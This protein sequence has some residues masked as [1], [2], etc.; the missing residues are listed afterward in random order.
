MDC[1][2]GGANG[3]CGLGRAGK[4]TA[5]FNRPTATVNSWKFR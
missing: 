1:G 3:D 4:G 2:I 5:Q